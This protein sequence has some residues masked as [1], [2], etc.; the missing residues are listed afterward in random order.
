MI[1]RIHITKTKEK[2]MK[3]LH[4]RTICCIVFSLLS[5]YASADK[6]MVDG[7]YYEINPQNDGTVAVVSGETKY[8]GEI[9]IPQLVNYNGFQYKVSQIGPKAFSMCEGTTSVVLPPS[10]LTIEEYAFDGCKNLTNVNL[11]ESLLKIGRNAFSN[12]TKLEVITMPNSL[13]EIGFDAFFGSGLKQLNI[14]A[15]VS[16]ISDNPFCGCNLLET[17][18]VDESNT[19]F[20][21]RDKCNAIIKDN[22]VIV[23]CKNSRVPYGITS[24]GSRAFYS[25]EG[26]TSVILPSSVT[27]IENFAFYLCKNLANIS[28]SESLVKIGKYAFTYDSK[29]EVVTFPY[30]LKEIG[31]YAFNA[32]GLQT[33]ISEIYTPFS[34]D[35]SVFDDNDHKCYNNATLYVKEGRLSSY[36]NAAGWKEFAKIQEMPPYISYNVGT[37][38]SSISYTLNPILKTGTILSITCYGDNITIPEKVTYKEEEYVINKINKGALAHQDIVT[39]TFPQL[40]QNLGTG[41]FEGSYKLSAIIWNRDDRPSDEMISTIE[42]P[43]LLFYVNSETAAP[44]NLPNVI[45]N[46]VA[47]NILL[48]DAPETNFYCPQR[49]RAEKITYTH[50]Y[51][52]KTEKG[53]AQGWESIALPFDVQKYETTNGEAKP[54]ASAIG[55]E[56]RFWLRELTSN[57]FME[58]NGIKANVPYIISMPNWIGY[59]DFYNIEGN[60]IFTSQDIIVPK[61]ELKKVEYDNM[62]FCPC[63]STLKSQPDIFV[64]NKEKIDNYA[65]GSSFMNNIRKANPFECYFSSTGMANT[66]A[67]NISSMLGEA[68]D[69]EQLTDRPEIKIENGTIYINSIRNGS[70]LI[71]SLTGQIIRKVILTSGQNAVSGLTRGTYLIE[72]NKYFVP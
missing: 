31:E 38:E 17:I 30:T 71:Y 20:D 21:S 49:F 48:L 14:P 15:N 72:G 8:E 63:F 36:Q 16:A 43:N 51:S 65:P 12:T 26:L 34:I 45:I 53:V 1:I 33:I 60:V 42:N 59:Q 22:V 58:T 9:V 10:V 54:Y 3:Y 68:T 64:L 29:L 56:R 4:I 50:R 19:I 5:S 70:L 13:K 41:M 25:C 37:M 57:G 39:V 62:I 23:G 67:L 69:I 66:R 32:S 7:L 40:K 47:K 27:T 35:K 55:G 6:F 44:N 61:T 52:L 18:E 2:T 46:G 28:L 24:I 11:S